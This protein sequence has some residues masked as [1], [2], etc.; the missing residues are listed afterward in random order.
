MDE[1]QIVRFIKNG[2]QEFCESLIKL[3]E[4]PL[5]RYCFHLCSNPHD[6]A[7]LFQET[8]F[9]AISKLKSYNEAYSFKNWLFTI[10]SNDFRDRYRKKVRRYAL[11]KRFSNTETMQ[12]EIETAKS[13][14]V[15][16]D[17]LMEREETNLQLKREVNGLKWHYKAVVVLHYFEGRSIRDVSEVLKIPEGTVKSRLAKARVILRERMQEAL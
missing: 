2:R 8:W 10:A 5:Y 1:K 7:D 11:E 3:Y 6:A 13:S 4:Q 17:V 15:P 12:K 14:D 16:A 9:K